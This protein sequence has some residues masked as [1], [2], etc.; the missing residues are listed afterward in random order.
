MVYCFY[1]YITTTGERNE[2]IYPLYVFNWVVKTK[3]IL[4]RLEFS[5]N[6][7]KVANPNNLWIKYFTSSKAVKDVRNLY[8]EPDIIQIRKTFATAKEAHS[9]EVRALKRLNAAK[10]EKFLNRHNGGECF[11]CI[12][13][14]PETLVKMS[15]FQKGK[16][17]TQEHKA[18][19]S[20]TLKATSWKKGVV[21][22][23]ETRSRKSKALTGII[24]TLEHQAKL[25]MTR[26]GTH[27]HYWSIQPV[28]SFIHK[29]GKQFFG[30]RREMK[31]RFPE[32]TSQYV[33]DI[34][35]GKRKSHKNWTIV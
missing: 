10:N 28:F 14:T 21:E 25:N 27:K 5:N 19:I 18:K 12:K 20:A 4:L 35:S 34:C 24:R 32:L 2:Y 9:W 6:R 26:G 30:T 23:Q 8:G 13:H 11:R 3:Q 1:K 15:V 7:A 17:K 31:V 22:S 16:N 29:S 33:D